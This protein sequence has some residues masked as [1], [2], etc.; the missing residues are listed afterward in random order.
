MC[1]NNPGAA[2]WIA[3]DIN[4]P[5]IEWET[6]SVTSYNVPIQVG[7]QRVILELTGYRWT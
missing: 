1:Q 6:H 7:H 5:D 3:G 2:V 4:V